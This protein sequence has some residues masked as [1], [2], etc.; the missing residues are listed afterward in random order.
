M[1]VARFPLTSSP[2]QFPSSTL[3]RTQVGLSLLPV[4]SFA[5]IYPFLVTQRMRTRLRTSSFPLS[6][7]TTMIVSALLFG[8]YYLLDICIYLFIYSFNFLWVVQLRYVWLY[9]L[10]SPRPPLVPIWW[11]GDLAKNGLTVDGSAGSRLPCCNKLTGGDVELC[12]RVSSGYSFF[13]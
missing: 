9:R 2:Y 12:Q 7:L 3:E 10:V 13:F 1:F 8:D 4:V 11:S 5:E 6:F